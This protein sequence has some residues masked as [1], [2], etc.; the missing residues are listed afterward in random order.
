MYRFTY[1]KAKNSLFFRK[2][3]RRANRGVC[4]IALNGKYVTLS[5]NRS[6]HDAQCLRI[7][8]DSF[9]LANQVTV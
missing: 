5:L 8:V 7:N 1:E 4:G 6:E 9:F 2:V 3:Q